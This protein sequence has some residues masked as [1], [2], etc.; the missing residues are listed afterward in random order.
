MKTARSL[1]SLLFCCAMLAPGIAAA[2]PPVKAPV[3]SP[4]NNPGALGPAVDV[5]VVNVE[6]Y[7]TDAG[8]K[9]V[10]GLRE[11]DF[12][13]REDG[14][15][16]SISNFAALAGSSAAA[17]KS[18]P[19][20][21]PEKP[22]ALQAE[23]AEP[24]NLIVFVDNAEIHPASRTRAL[25]QVRDFLSQKLAPGDRVMVVSLDAG[26]RVRLPFSTDRAAVDAAL[27]EVEGLATQGLSIDRARRQ[28]Y[29]NI[30][31]VQ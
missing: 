23:P 2:A 15:R 31:T 14:R 25:Q 22:E 20:D 11:R 16:V 21:R 19:A 4:I 5:N 13:V 29:Q 8:G 18:A 6:V 24:W 26:L 12:E 28:A 7:V 1:F 10:T 9:P 27:K 30:L 3:N 17:R